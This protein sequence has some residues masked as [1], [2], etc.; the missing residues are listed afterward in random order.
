M[1]RLEQR[2]HIAGRGE[3]L[4]AAPVAAAADGARLVEGDVADLAGR[5]A[6]A[7]VDLAADHQAGADAAGDLDV[8][9]VPHAPPAAPD[10]LAEGAEVGVVVHVH[11]HAEPPPQLLGGLGAAPAGQDGGRAQRP[12]LHVDRAG[13][14]QTHARDLGAV[15]AGGRDQPADQLFRP[16]EAL[17]GGGVDVQRLGLL[18]EHLVRQVPDRD[19]Q[20]RVPEVDADDDARVPAQGDAAGPAAPRRGGRDLDGPAVLQFPDDVRDGRRGQAR[21]PRDLRLRERPGEPYRSHDPF[22]VGSVQ[23]RLRPGSLH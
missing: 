5:A 10:Q 17:G 3:G 4:Q 16:V 18:G 6:G 1:A 8:R 2:E 22:Q 9:Q 19:A 7:A 13:H 21:R 14:A 15:D 23:R 20:M 12:G 11:R